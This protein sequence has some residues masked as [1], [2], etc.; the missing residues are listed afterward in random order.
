MPL[1]RLLI[2]NRGEIAIRI[3]RAAAELG[4]R[5]GGDPLRGRRRVAARCA[6]GTRRAPG[7]GP[8]PISTSSRSSSAARAAGCDAI[9]PGYGFLTENADFA[10]RCRAAGLTFVGP[11]AETLELFG[12]KAAG[13]ARSRGDSASRCWPA[14]S[15]RLARGSACV[16]STLGRSE[17]DHAQG[18]RRRRRPRHA[19]RDAT[20]PSS[21]TAFARCRSEAAA[22]FGSDDLYVERVLP[23]ARH[24]E[25]QIVGDAHGAVVHLGERD[26][27]CSAATR[28]WSRSHPARLWRRAA[29]PAARLRPC[30]WRARPLSSNFGTFEFLVDARGGRR[31][32]LR[33]HRSQPA[34]AGRAHGDRGGARRRPR[35]AQLR[36]AGGRDARRAAVCT[37][38]QIGRPRGF[39]IQLRVNME[40]MTPDGTRCRPAACCGFEPPAGPASASIRSATPAIA[41]APA[42]TRCSPR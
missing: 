19:R 14:P 29:R 41:R 34:A 6:G 3:V 27:T 2:A 15:P 22:A 37:Q 10:R 31:R 32:A 21:T 36:I 8:R 26:C 17:R 40:T 12:D 18:G 24:I 42:S 16:P 35:P 23:D 1:Q 39:A 30:G 20:S 25:V 5:H 13:R 28:S 9:H 4:H 7:S 11:R 33:L 38:A